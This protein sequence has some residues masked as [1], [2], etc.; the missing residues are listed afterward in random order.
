MKYFFCFIPKEDAKSGLNIGKTYAYKNKA[1]W[2]ETN[3]IGGF[4]TVG[5]V[6][7]CDFVVHNGKTYS[8]MKSYTDIADKSVV[9]LA[10]ESISGCDID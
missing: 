3:W 7:G 2:V 9:F 6:K 10:V 8:I 5:Y 1:K 4:L